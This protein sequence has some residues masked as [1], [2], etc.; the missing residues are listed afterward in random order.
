MGTFLLSVFPQN[1]YKMVVLEPLNKLLQQKWETFASK[2]FYFSFV[3]YLSF[4]IIFTAIAYYQPSRVKVGPAL[5]YLE[6][7]GRT[8]VKA[9]GWLSPLPLPV[10]SVLG[11]FIL[12]PSFPVEFTTGGFLWVSGL[13]II[14]LG[15]VYLIFAQVWGSLG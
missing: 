1:R 13:I 9:V 11:F 2:R 12:Q 8:E 6:R 3:S 5:R 15:G 4:M 7:P 14:L 10:F